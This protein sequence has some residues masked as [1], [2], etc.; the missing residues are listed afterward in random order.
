EELI[1]IG[2]RAGRERTA[3]DSAVPVDAFDLEQLAAGGQTEVARMLQMAAPSF[4]FSTSTISDGTDIVRPAT[5][6]GM[7]PDQTLV[8]VN[9][10][11]R[12][13]SALMH[14]NG[15][16]GR[17]TAGVDLNAIPASSIQRIEVLRDG[18][19]AQYGSDAIAGVI[20]V[21]LKDQT[22]TIDPFIQYGQTFESDGENILGSIN[23]GFPIL[24][25]G[26]VNATLEYRDRSASNRAGLDMRQQF[27]FVEQV[28]GQPQLGLND[29]PA[30]PGGL[31][32][33]RADEPNPAG[34]ESGVLNHRYGDPDSENLYF[35][36]NAALPLGATELYT[37]GG[38]AQR[39]GQSGGFFRRNYDARSVPAIHPDGFLPLINTNVDDTSAGL[40]LRW[41]L[42]NA[43]WDL[44][45][46]YGEN[47][48]EF[49]ITNSNN[50]ALGPNS[51]TS[52]NAG[53]L[54]T[55]LVV[56]NLDASWELDWFQ[57][58]Q[59]SAGLEWREDKYTL[60]P[61]ETNSFI[62]AN[63][64]PACNRAS[65]PT[66]ELD[67]FDN[68]Y[69]SSPGPD[70]LNP[71]DFDTAAAGIQVFPGFQPSNL[72]DDSRDAAAIYADLEMDLTERFLLGAAVRFEDYSD[73]GNTLNGKLAA[74]WNV[75][76]NVALR[77]SVSTGFRA[78]S[79]QQQ[80]FNNISTQ[81]VSIGG[82]QTP[83]EVGTFANDSPVVSQGFGIPQLQE[84]TSTNISGGFSWTPTDSFTATVDLYYIA[85]EDRVVLSGRFEPESI[86][87]DGQ[88]CDATNSNCPIAAILEP[89]N[90]N[91][92]QFFSN[93][94]DT[95]TTGVDIVVDYA[96]EL[97]GGGFL[98]LGAGL[99]FNRIVQDG[100]TRVP[101]TLV[102]SPGAD[103]TLYSRQE[104]LWLEQGQ[105]R[106]HWILSAAYD[107]GKFNIFT[108]A[109]WFGP[110]SSAESAS[111]P[112]LD[113]EFSGK[114]LVDLEAGWAFTDSIKVVL[115]ANNI[116]DTTPDENI[117]AN[118]FGG[119]F[120]YNRRTTPFG[121]NG[122][123]Y[124]GRIIMSFGTGL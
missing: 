90:I 13:N 53:T 19:A 98:K 23:A 59:L 72:R 45:G 56:F 55:E 10:K 37:F 32:T 109:N 4:N 21:I 49:V 103:E 29:C 111:D 64:D 107:R 33:Y 7:Q 43:N 51:P 77:A 100:A 104:R 120:P 108:K 28:E 38:I 62:G 30:N 101:D 17:G 65:N 46:T 6:R 25:E 74:R 1:T 24:G 97:S 113:Q 41:E 122:G 81:F 80:F 20:N 11:R 115:G 105:P 106:Q 70:L 14:V 31:C 54:G 89:F 91:S 71:N 114:W 2:A 118:S 87:N 94:I 69:S 116:F 42:L 26:F 95:E 5:L 68:Q 16:I 34:D 8:L 3:V 83:T 61:G 119:I 50:V 123:F 84:E 44:S 58:S 121:F 22:E 88:P 75:V 78:P 63:T 67:C 92:A 86:G 102:N 18:A 76:D 47:E 39:E 82:V 124:Y 60:S 110:V 93:A 96:T 99:N 40:G 66:S 36:W 112:S 35:F 73:F 27:N 15:S 12:H 9:G 52:A 48:F 79:L 117:A 85:V 57:S